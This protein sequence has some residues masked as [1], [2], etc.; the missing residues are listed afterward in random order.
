M[1]FVY[2]SSRDHDGFVPLQASKASAM[3]IELLVVA[4]ILMYLNARGVIDFNSPNAIGIS[5]TIILGCFVAVWAAWFLIARVV[6][7]GLFGFGSWAPKKTLASSLNASNVKVPEKR[8]EAL[9]K[10]V[11]EAPRDAELSRQYSDQLLIR[12]MVEEFVAERL[13][14][15]QTGNLNTSEKCAIFNRLADIELERKQPA[16]AVQYLNEIA[17]GYSETNEGANARKRIKYIENMIL[18]P[19]ENESA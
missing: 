12:G 11:Q 2:Y 5:V 7:D 6:V 19:N 1:S 3:L 8:F 15:L 18:P 10:L 17:K 16:Q 13:R 14:I 9:Q 4:A